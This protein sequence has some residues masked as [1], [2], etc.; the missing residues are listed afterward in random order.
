MK[1]KK[2]VTT[3]KRI[4]KSIIGKPPRLYVKAVF[5]GF[6]RGKRTQDENHAL[7]H[8]E[9]LNSRKEAQY[10]LG[11]RIVYV[12]RTKNGYKSIWGRICSQHGNNGTC[13]AKFLRNL[14]PKAIGSTL[15]V[16]LYPQRA[17]H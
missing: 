11:K 3:E 4:R 8:I 10:Y 6:R 9:G 15:R 1:G 7:V 17:T 14:P 12:Y 2:E 5:S 13:K 16:M